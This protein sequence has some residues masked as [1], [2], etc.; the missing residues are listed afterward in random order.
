MSE[1]PVLHVVATPIGNL[2]DITYRAVRVLREVDALA[3]ED[4]R[5]TRILLEHY[6]IA[7]PRHL[8][9]YHNYNESPAAERILS[10]LREGCRV[11]LCT[12]AGCPSISDP[13]YTIVSRTLDAGF[14][15]EVIPGASAVQTALVASGL[16]ASTY[17]FKGFP[18]RRPGRRKTFLAM[19]AEAP[20]SLVFFEAPS[21]L[22]RFLGEALEVLG[23]R[24]AAVC[25]ELTKRFER[26]QRGLLSELRSRFAEGV[27]RGEFT[28]VIAGRHPKFMA[29][30]ED[31]RRPAEAAPGESVAGPVEP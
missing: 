25:S 4:T 26:V 17:T 6:D 8:I 7:R 10:L 20:H 22:A 14:R 31:E 29:D 1:L 24:Q 9:A 19:E 3:C 2:E 28:I 30:S 21:R 18:P 16:P 13:G 15:V 5:H 27:A 23:D 11:A 12:N